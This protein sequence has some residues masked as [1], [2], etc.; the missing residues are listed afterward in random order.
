MALQ[1]AYRGFGTILCKPSRLID[2][3]KVDVPNFS[4]SMIQCDK[5]ST[6][7]DRLV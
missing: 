1:K 3:L 5:F 4:Y 6:F 2:V 7:L